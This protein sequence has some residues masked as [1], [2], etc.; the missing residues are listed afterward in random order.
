[1]DSL[2][3]SLEVFGVTQN[4]KKFEDSIDNIFNNL[5]IKTQE[6]QEQPED[7]DKEWETLKMNYSKLRYI[8]QLLNHYNYTLPDRFFVLL[9]AFTDSLDGTTQCYIEVIEY[10]K[11]DD[12]ELKQSYD[13]IKDL[14][15]KSLNTHDQIDK[16]KY[17]LK[18]YDILV[19]IIEDFRRE[20]WD[21]TFYSPRPTKRLKK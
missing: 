15:N 5:S 11:C 20:S 14:F 13:E 4:K 19:P 7:P 18:A 16:I 2:I 21:D 17:I 12:E 1:M 10:E 6:E 9:R 3:K 8:Y